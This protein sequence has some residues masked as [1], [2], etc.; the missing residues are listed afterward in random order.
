MRI[1]EIFYIVL[2]LLFVEGMAIGT[3]VPAR[4]S[5]PTP[6]PTL[7]PQPSAQKPTAKPAVE[8][9]IGD[10]LAEPYFI[11]MAA[12]ITFCVFALG[13]VRHFYFIQAEEKR[14]KQIRRRPEPA[15]RVIDPWSSL[16]LSSNVD[17]GSEEIPDVSP[18]HENPGLRYT[19]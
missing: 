13:C 6:N 12:G 16:K 7:K 1:K 14:E 2:L 18:P 9:G 11:L 15:D 4:S 19:M 17:N 3:P 10:T 5:K 8:E